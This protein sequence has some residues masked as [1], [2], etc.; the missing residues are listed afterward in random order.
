MKISIPLWEQVSDEGM[1]YYIEDRIDHYIQHQLYHLG[2]LKCDEW[3][4]VNYMNSPVVVPPLD[5][6]VKETIEKY[7]REKTT[8]QEA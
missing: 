2:I 8:P 3:N 4:H 6:K 7:C 1:H 5:V